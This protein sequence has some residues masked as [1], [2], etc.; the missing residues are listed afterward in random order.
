[1]AARQKSIL[2]VEDD[3]Q[4]RGMYRLALSFAGFNV[5]EAQDGLHAL[6]QIDQQ[7]P[8]LIVLDLGLPILS[9]VSVQQ[10]VAAHA[11]TRHIP[12]VVVTGSTIDFAESEVTCV[13]RKPVWP[14][15]LVKAV[16][17]CLSTGAPGIGA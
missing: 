11:H 1:M 6:R 4:L 17:S 12:I 13:L 14:D 9:G 7:P 8:D 10:D 5:S 16:Q 15:D 2:I 3:A